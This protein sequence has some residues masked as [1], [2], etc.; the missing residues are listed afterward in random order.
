M[1]P[2]VEKAPEQ[3]LG[4]FNDEARTLSENN[5][6]GRKTQSVTYPGF[7][8]AHHERNLQRLGGTRDNF[9]P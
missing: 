4:I 5:P 6:V 7:R 8:S 1:R 2:G 9:S 3:R